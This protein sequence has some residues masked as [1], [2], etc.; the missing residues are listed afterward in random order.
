VVQ[1]PSSAEPR[2]ELLAEI[3]VGNTARVELCRVVGGARN[4]DLCAVKRLHAH[5]A[6]DPA[7]VDMFRDEVWMTAALKNPHVVEMLGWGNDPSGPWLA[8]ELVRGVSLAR[9]MKTV[10]ETGEMF[11]ERLVVYIARSISDGLAAAHAL[12][13][14]TG[15]HLGLVHRDLTPGNVLLGFSGEV[16]I[17]DFGLAKAKQRVTRTLTGLLKGNP[18]YMSPEQVKNEPLD[19]RSD[20][21]AVGVLLFELFS[22]RRPWN[23]NNDFE[24]MRAITDEA[25]LDLLEVRPKLDRAL[26]RLVSRCLEKNPADRFQSAV[27]LAQRLDE[28]LEAHGYRDDNDGALGRFVRRNA[29]RQMRWFERATSLESQDA[30]VPPEVEGDDFAS[31]WATE[32]GPTL[33][34]GTDHAAAL[35]SELGGNPSAFV[36]EGT[37]VKQLAK[38]GESSVDFDN[39]P[40]GKH[41]P[42]DASEVVTV[43]GH[44]GARLIGFGDPALFRGEDPTGFASEASATTPYF[45]HRSES[46]AASEPPRGSVRPPHAPD[47]TILVPSTPPPPSDQA[48]DLVLRKRGGRVVPKTLQGLGAM[49]IPDV[50]V[51]AHEEPAAHPDGMG[52]MPSP[53]PSAPSAPLPLFAM[54]AAAEVEAVRPRSASEGHGP[55][56][57]LLLGDVAGAGNRRGAQVSAMRVD[58]SRVDFSQEVDRLRSLADRTVS[59]ARLA[60]D[61]AAAAQRAARLGAEA[62]TL[63]ARGLRAE[64]VERLEEARRIERGVA[65]GQVIPAR[66][67]A[68]DGLVGGVESVFAKQLEVVRRNLGDRQFV[69]FAMAA[70]AAVLVVVVVLVAWSP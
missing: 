62:S 13:G 58:G 32:E 30:D 64:A 24:T 8:V 17:T 20:I 6:E 43:P 68:S 12:R 18:Q 5:V 69:W 11:S 55:P 25:P 29:M 15:D 41:R 45:G 31:D 38:T 49:P 10:F 16:K 66:T 23:T 57:H 40:T 9:L 1:D 2:F 27:E 37:T 35:V 47:E 61:L 28:W 54:Q 33:V 60:A 67:L 34:H 50:L 4:G 63:A 70:V 42:R 7:F 65:A 51:S 46:P 48:A 39:L 3:A 59:D 19:A 56:A 21:F 52:R 44:F 22:G 53:T 36:V 26:G 14:A